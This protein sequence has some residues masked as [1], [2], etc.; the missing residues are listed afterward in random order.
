MRR[1]IF[2]IGVVATIFAEAP[3][4]AAESNHV[5]YDLDTVYVEG[6]RDNKLP[7][8]YLNKTIEFGTLGGRTIMETPMTAYSFNQK[9]IDDYGEPGL[10]ANSVL[11]NAPSIR[12]GATLTHNDFSI[13]GHYMQ[14]ASFYVNGIPGLYSQM[15]SPT[16]NIQ[17]IQYISGPSMIGGSHMEKNAVAGYIN[18]VSKRATDKPITRYTQ[19]FSGKGNWGEYIDVG[20]RFGK[21]NE[22]GIRVNAEYADGETGIKNSNLRTKGVFVNVDHNDKKSESNLLVGY[23][24]QRVNRGMRWFLLDNKVTKL[25]KITDISKNVS[26]DQ[27]LKEEDQTLL[28]LNHVQKFNDNTKLFVNIGLLNSDLKRNISPQ[29]S[30]YTILNNNGDYRFK[31]YNGR[32]PNTYRYYEFG[33][34]KDITIGKVKNELVLSYDYMW[35]NSYTNSVLNKSGKEFFYGNIYDGAPVIPFQNLPLPDK[36]LS[37][38]TRLNG[39][40]LTDTIKQGK[41]SLTLGMHHH[42]ADVKKFNV[43]GIQT[44]R[45]TASATSPIFGLVYQPTKNLSF[46]ASHTE[47]FSKGDIVAN[48][49]ENRGE[50][51]RPSKSKENEI[52]IKW[53]NRHVYGSISG[54]DIKEK[55]YVDDLRED[56]LYR[57]ENG[58]T[59]YKGLEVSVNADVNDKLSVFGG[60][61]YVNPKRN[62]TDRGLLD[63]KIV[64]GSAKWNGVLGFNYKFT[65]KFEMYGRML[66]MGVT[67]DYNEKIKLPGYTTFDF[68]A[69]HAFNVWGT[70]GMITVACYNVTNK[71]YWMTKGSKEVLFGMP[72]TF[73]VSAQFDF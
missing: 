28:A 47:A 20:N 51:L 36:K 8:K 67:Y 48:K 65:P 39:Y 52:G 6:K 32:T 41:F 21:N 7:G 35:Q 29:S 72:R 17:E 25:P 22:W 59:E 18:F 5:Q 45:I 49:Y 43:Q 57:T 3:A 38:K 70:K 53:E 73:M 55:G 63:G 66:A 33:L 30:A 56:G 68:G 10:S 4:F 71:N 60:A 14:G 62:K 61:M 46:Y 11:R 16:Y 1:K 44:S 64:D 19:T 34:Q 27:M 9:A 12:G 50:L 24:Y 13:R 54:F 58:E 23:Q 69:R 26:F 31:V 42:E 2:L 15:I 40:S 37:A